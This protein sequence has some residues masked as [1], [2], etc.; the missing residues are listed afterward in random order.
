[1]FEKAKTDK[2]SD[3][4]ETKN[5]IPI[6]REFLESID[7][8]F[9]AMHVTI[10][11]IEYWSRDGFI[12]H[13][14]NRGGMDL[15]AFTD[16]ASLIGSGYH[17][18]KSIEKHVEDI[19][20]KDFEE[21]K[22]DNPNLSEEDIYEMTNEQNSC[23]YSMLAWRIRVMYEGD[24]RLIVY[25][26]WDKDAPYFP[27]KDKAESEHEINFKDNDDLIKQLTQ[28]ALNINYYGK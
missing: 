13:G 17:S 21:N 5:L 2:A 27:W 16:I 18:G 22:K 12:A 24:N 15:I 3:N 25:V 28:L 10:E 8:P 23:D 9:D 20:Y 19:Y 14:H 26:G 11:E 7:P 4:V 6:I 1:M